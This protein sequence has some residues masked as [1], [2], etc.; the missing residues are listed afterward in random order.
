MCRRRGLC[1]SPNGSAGSSTATAANTTTAGPR[2]VRRRHLVAG[3]LFVWAR[4]AEALADYAGAYLALMGVFIFAPEVLI[5]GPLVM[6]L[7]TRKAAASASGIIGTI[8]YA[9]AALMSMVS[10]EILDRYDVAG[11]PM[12]GWHVLF[13]IW[14]GAALLSALLI[15]PLWRF[16]PGEERYY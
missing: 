16:R 10:G 11:R 8:G 2:S 13:H 6:D 1:A 15:L 5:V 3:L 7:A 14:A 12:A 4:Y 9:G